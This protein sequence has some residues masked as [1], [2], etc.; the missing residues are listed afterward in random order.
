MKERTEGFRFKSF[1]IELILSHLCDQG[2]DF[3][4]YPE[5]L[6]HFFTYV[7]QEQHAGED[8][9]QRLLRSPQASELFSTRPDH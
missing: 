5:A 9:F 7:A 1:M 2:L 8:R 6:Q 3:S 4:D